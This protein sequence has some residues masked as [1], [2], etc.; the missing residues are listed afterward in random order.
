[1]NSGV[2]AGAGVVEQCQIQLCAFLTSWGAIVEP[3]PWQHLPCASRGRCPS[4]GPCAVSIGL[5]EPLHADH[6]PAVD[7]RL[8]QGRLDPRV[9][10]VASEEDLHLIGELCC[11]R[12][13]NCRR[14]ATKRVSGPRR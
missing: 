10:G 6:W 4:L 1:M 2:A 11:S 3:D 14:A 5:P 7:V 8:R 12:R 13:Y 9:H